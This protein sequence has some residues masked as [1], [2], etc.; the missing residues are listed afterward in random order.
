[1]GQIGK[2][3]KYFVKPGVS[4][5][6]GDHCIVEIERGLEYAIVLRLI[7]AI[8]RTKEHSGLKKIIR[9]A[10]SKDK[11]QLKKNIQLG[12]RAR[13][14]CQEKIKKKALQMKLIFVNYTFDGKKAI[15]YFISESR[16]DFR[17]LVKELASEFKT[18]I[19]MRQIGVRDEAKILGGM[20]SCGRILCCSSYLSEFMPVSIRMVKDQNLT[21]NPNK[22]S[23]ICGRLRCCLAYEYPLYA[24][25][26]SLL[27]KIG[28]RVF[29]KKKEAEGKVISL[30]ILK[31][32]VYVEYEDG[33]RTKSDISQIIRKN[34]KG[35]ENKEL[36]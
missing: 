12:Q 18:R 30:D 3:A 36:S 20:G 21:L 19:E 35:K 31:K 1:L 25:F 26:K 22:I 4:V 34:S 13:E 27:P 24:E 2:I 17:N 9:I 7:N 29:E 33:S 32:I 6:E 5:K 28:E 8:P 11:E 15:F 16:I 14:L 23:G 10:T